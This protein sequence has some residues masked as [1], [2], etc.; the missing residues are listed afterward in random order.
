MPESTLLRINQV[1]LQNVR[2]FED[3][4]ADL[5]PEVT[6]LVGCNGSGKTAFVEALS[7]GLGALFV[8]M[9]NI[10]VVLM[11]QDDRRAV[12]H[13]HGGMSAVEHPT[14][15]MIDVGGVLGGNMER[16]RVA[17]RSRASLRG[18]A[19]GQW[20]TRMEQAVGRGK[21]VDLPVIACYGADRTW[22]DEGYEDDLDPGSR[23]DGYNGCLFA[24]TGFRDVT[25]WM[26]RLT[27]ASSR[28]DEAA[29]SAET[30]LRGIENA[31]RL[32]VPGLQ[33]LFYDIL[34]EEL[35]ARFTDGR[36]QPFRL[37]SDGFRITLGLVA[38]LAWRAL[39]LN[40]HL[41]ADAPTRA[42]GVV[43][44]DEID[45]H[46]HPSWQ[47][48]ILG[49]LRRAFP[50]IQLVVTTHSPQV[51]ASAKR[52][53]V[54]RITPTSVMPVGHVEGR[55]SNSLLVELFG[56]RERPADTEACLIELFQFIDQDRTEDA[57]RLMAEL[58]R[59]LGFDD[60]ELVRARWLLAGLGAE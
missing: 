17:I 11:R 5:H 18:S 58:E 31:T 29:K 52:E 12:V 48:R 32:A 4:T 20:G 21:A 16:W 26:R 40:P 7:V 14:P 3:L 23:L 10:K 56:D 36:V 22:R 15:V 13:E 6:L 35:R 51:I 53:W 50:G 9:E 28:R 45:L 30:H 19:A 8:G 38:D 33:G 27:Y 39:R 43:I 54:R 44:I 1:H 25:T 46:L 59:T 47:R 37:L 34:A 57:Q 41:G 2:C 49:D 60:A 55:D 42:E 24:A